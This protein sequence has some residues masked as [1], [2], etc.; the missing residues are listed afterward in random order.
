MRSGKNSAQLCAAGYHP[1][2]ALSPPA[3]RTVTTPTLCLPLLRCHVV[4]LSAVSGGGVCGGAL[5]HF[6][7]HFRSRF[8][9][10]PGDSGPSK[11]RAGSPAHTHAL[12]WGP[13]LVGVGVPAPMLHPHVGPAPVTLDTVVADVLCVVGMGTLPPWGRFGFQ[14]GHFPAPLGVFRCVPPLGSPV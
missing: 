8:W 3:R 11:P 6:R 5:G 10:H 1:N 13:G 4:F 14:S 9:S 2:A 12:S 7:G